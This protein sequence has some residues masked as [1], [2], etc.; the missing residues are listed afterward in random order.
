M[1]CDPVS[2]TSTILFFIQLFL[3]IRHVVVTQSIPPLC[4]PGI[5]I[6]NEVKQSP[7]PAKLFH[8][9]LNISQCLG[10]QPKHL[11]IIDRTFWGRIPQRNLRVILFD[12]NSLDDRWSYSSSLL[13][14]CIRAWLCWAAVMGPRGRFFFFF[15]E[16]EGRWCFYRIF[17]LDWRVYKKLLQLSTDYIR[18]L[19]Y[20]GRQDGQYIC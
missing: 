15:T 13:P 7:L 17:S 10:E 5:C 1:E 12:I 6:R 8:Y 9:L 3:K 14:C 4:F 11:P 19:F 20:K 16:T 18:T 2:R